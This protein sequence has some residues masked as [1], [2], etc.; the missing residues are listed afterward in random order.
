MIKKKGENELISS[1]WP[2]CW[3]QNRKRWRLSWY[4]YFAPVSPFLWEV[5]ADGFQK[6]ILW[7]SRWRRWNEKLDWSDRQGIKI[8]SAFRL[9]SIY[10]YFIILR[11]IIFPYK[12][13]QISI[14]N[15][16]FLNVLDF[17]FRVR[18][19]VVIRVDF[20]SEVLKISSNEF[21]STFITDVS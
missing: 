1:I 3:V 16:S 13:F 6:V 2:S 7:W 12:L 10:L 4:A 19:S 17:Y 20:E 5:Q 8:V 9:Y 14:W 18:G 15:D 11:E 21:L